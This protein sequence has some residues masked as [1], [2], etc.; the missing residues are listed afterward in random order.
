MHRPFVRLLPLCFLALACTEPILVEEKTP[1]AG[2]AGDP[3]ADEADR[4]SLG[5]EQQVPEDAPPSSRPTLPN[6]VPAVP[7][8]DPCI[9]LPE[10]CRCAEACGQGTC[11]NTLCPGADPCEPV[12]ER[13]FF[14]TTVSGTRTKPQDQDDAM[15]LSLVHF[16]PVTEEAALVHYDGGTDQKAPDFKTLFQDK[17]RPEFVSTAVEPNPSWP[18]T[19]LGLRTLP[20]EPIRAPV[21]GYDLGEGV[22]CIVLFADN[23]SVT[24]KYTR[25][26]D[27]V[28]GYAL[29]VRGICVDERLSSLFRQHASSPD[30]R[31]ALFPGQAFGRAIGDSIEIAVRD[32]GTL[33]DP[34]SD[35]DWW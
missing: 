12:E 25:E 13:D 21:S 35:K 9:P 16:S 17:R 11:D 34:R 20:G 29:Y 33:M 32:S 15:D 8:D 14:L 18:V 30:R 4:P 6:D 1:P 5:L 10:L 28:H 24:C 3:L 27:I 23:D 2:T 31:P 26:D 7:P 22:A 19:L